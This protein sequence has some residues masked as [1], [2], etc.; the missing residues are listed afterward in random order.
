MKRR[1]I[2]FVCKVWVFLSPLT[3]LAFGQ[4][5]GSILYNYIDVSTGVPRTQIASINP[6]GSSDQ[7]VSLS[8]LNPAYAAWSRDGQLLAVAGGDPARPSKLSTDVYLFRPATGQ[9]T[10]LSAFE[11]TAG[12][13]GFI[14]FYPSYLAISPDG[15]RV[16]AGMVTYVGA[17]ATFAPT[18]EFGN[19]LTTYNTA[20]KISRCV[21]LLVFNANGS[22]PVL[23][24]TA[25]CDDDLAH[26]GEGVDW[27]PTQDLIAYPF[28]TPTVFAGS[29]GQFNITAIFLTE[30]TPGAADQ[31]K[32]RQITFPTGLTGGPFDTFSAAWYDDFA[33]A[34]SPD[35]RQMAYV[36]CLSVV[37][38]G[39]LY[40]L[41]AVPSIRIVG[42]DGSND[43]EVAT[44]QRGS[45]LTRLSWSPD[46]KQLVFDLG[47]QATR[48]GFPLRTFDLNT[49]TLAKIN[50]DGTGF[51]Q[52]RGARATWPA[53]QPGAAQS[54]TPAIANL[55]PTTLPANSAGFDLIVNGSGFTTNSV[56]QW[57]GAA[58]PTTFISSTQ[59]RGA[60][61][62][63]RLTAAAQIL[64]SVSNGS[65][66]ASLSN[67]ANFTITESTSNTP[68]LLVSLSGGTTP[69]ITFAW[70][71]RGTNFVVESSS[72]LG[73]Q[74]AWAS[75]G[76]TPITV[77]GQSSV[78]LS[79]S[80]QRAFF[81]LK[82]L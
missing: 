2:P 29:G 39:A 31:G 47:Q 24:G 38:P 26:P 40:P 65:G 7:F 35:G 17:R 20:S 22:A 50:V 63:T 43:R 72:T 3:Q 30:T 76:V 66:A 1:T 78:T 12:A 71:D 82:R 48:E 60:V 70:A 61:T 57:N 4:F 51:A 10:K 5:S 56:V 15:Q 80:G 42:S 14:T 79:A 53:W 74:A 52:V 41:L 6:D 81:R 58:I 32:R 73:L 25:L 77:N 75:V 36:R 69:S 33:P 44:F 18:N 16:A 8:L 27:S 13:A 62:A 68:R 55:Q 11:D 9:I 67:T 23:V 46:A 21:S 28:N 19:P 59:L 34:F 64:I 49:V 54:S 45:Y 37:V